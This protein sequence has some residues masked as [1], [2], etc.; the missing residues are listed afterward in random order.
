M[1]E[2]RT[3]LYASRHFPGMEF[4]GNAA[5]EAADKLRLAISRGKKL[6]IYETHVPVAGRLEKRESVWSVSHEKAPASD[7][8]LAANLLYAK[9]TTAELAWNVLGRMMRGGGT[10]FEFVGNPSYASAL[11]GLKFG[12]TTP[13]VFGR[14]SLLA[15]VRGPAP[16]KAHHARMRDLL[17]CIG[18]TVQIREIIIAIPAAGG[19]NGIL[20]VEGEPGLYAVARAVQLEDITIVNSLRFLKNAQFDGE[21]GAKNPE[22]GKIRIT[23]PGRG[24]KQRSKR[25]EEPSLLKELCA[26]EARVEILRSGVADSQDE[27]GEGKVKGVGDLEKEMLGGIESIEVSAERPGEKWCA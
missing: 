1:S 6:E 15:A 21:I 5:V 7:L 24:K 4:R 9:T 17:A 25:K 19:E 18:A 26:A 22:D 11:A 14:S 20:A 13:L 27:E 2:P 12:N 23:N 8:T 3:I 16:E 10:E